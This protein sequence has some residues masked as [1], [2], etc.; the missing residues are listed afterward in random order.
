MDSSESLIKAIDSHF[1]TLHIVMHIN[2]GFIVRDFMDNLNPAKFY[3]FYINILDI[4]HKTFL[5]FFNLINNKKL[6][7][8][9]IMLKLM[10][11]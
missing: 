1:P 4:R 2:V 9:L 8:F 6:E 7:C 11:R 3:A 10:L 5:K